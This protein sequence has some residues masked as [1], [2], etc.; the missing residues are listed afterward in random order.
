MMLVGLLRGSVMFMTDLMRS[1][2]VRRLGILC[3]FSSYS[4]TESS[5]FVRIDSDHKS[6]SP[7]GWNHRG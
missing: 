6:S 2:R 3:C 5:G 4:G 1:I 7:L